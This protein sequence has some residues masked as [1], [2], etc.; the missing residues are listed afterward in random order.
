MFPA[1]GLAA[2]FAT[3]EDPRRRLLALRDPAL[4]AEALEAF[5]RDPEWE[6]RRRAARDPRMPLARIRELPADFDTAHHA[7]GNPAL[8][9][10]DMHRFLDAAG[11]AA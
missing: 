5:T 10:E 9:V 8:P 6:C 4:T 11:V 2:R 3:S 7:A 1:A